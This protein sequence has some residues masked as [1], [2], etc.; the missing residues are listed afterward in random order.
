MLAGDA[1]FDGW[2]YTL[3]LLAVFWLFL[4]AVYVGCDG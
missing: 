2:L 4:L 1:S 3:A